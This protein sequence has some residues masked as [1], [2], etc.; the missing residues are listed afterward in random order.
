MLAGEQ[1]KICAR[2]YEEESHGYKS[3]R[4]IENKA[5]EQRCGKKAI[6]ELIGKTVADGTLNASLQY[7][8]LRLGNTCNMQCIMCRP[9]ES[10]RW[11]AAARTLSALSQDPQLRDEWSFR[12]RINGSRFEWYRNSAFWANLKSFL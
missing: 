5:W 8:D 3:L 1:L 6:R 12:A 10:S 4:L 9:R 2:C 11:V 7:I